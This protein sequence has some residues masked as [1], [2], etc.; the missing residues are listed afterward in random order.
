MRIEY[1]PFYAWRVLV[2]RNIARHDDVFYAT[3]MEELELFSEEPFPVHVDGEP[4]P[5]VTSIHFSC[6]RDAL[7][8]RA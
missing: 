2:T 1:L 4:L 5:A 3:N 8:V 6:V 7:R